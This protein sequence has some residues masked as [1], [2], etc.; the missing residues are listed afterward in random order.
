MTRLAVL[1]CSNCGS[2]SPPNAKFC[3]ECGATL[4]RPDAPAA[5]TVRAAAREPARGER[6]QLTVMF[7]DL[8]GS[9]ALAERLDPE[10]LGDILHAYHRVCSRIVERFGGHIHQYLGDGVMAYFSYPRAQE[11]A[12]QRSLRAALAIVE[13][14]ERLRCDRGQPLAVRVGIHTGLVVVGDHTLAVGETPNIAARLQALADPNTVVIGAATQRLVEQDFE[15]RPLGSYALKGLSRPL[16]VYRVEREHMARNRFDAEAAAALTPLVGRDRELGRLLANWRGA[17][18]GRGRAVLIRGEPGIGKSRLLTALKAEVA[19]CPGAW[20][21]ECYSSPCYQSRLLHPVAKLLSH[22]VLRFEPGD[23]PAVKLRKLEGWLLQ[24]GLD[25]ERN[26]PLLAGLL[27]L[28]LPG[29]PRSQLTLAAQ[30]ALETVLLHILLA[31]AARQPVLVAFEDLHWADTATLALLERLLAAVADARVLVV[32]TARSGFTPP[33][34][35]AAGLDTLDLA[36]LPAGQTERLARLVA[37][38]KRLPR[39]LLARLVERSDGVPLFVEELTRS[40][41]ESGLLREREDRFEA[42]GPVPTLPIPATLHDALAFRLEQAYPAKAVAQLAATLGRKFSYGLLRAVCPLD[43]GTLMEGLR[44]LERMGL[45]CRRGAGTAA[46]YSFRHAL[47]QEKAYGSLL[48]SVRRRYHSRISRC[49]D[50]AA[51]APSGPARA[52]LLRRA[53]PS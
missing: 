53:V 48:R 38:G 6:R 10:E 21:V 29:R 20:L 44:Q 37:K 35:W 34:G 1:H 7:C 11:D 12:A 3:M 17:A 16:P 32:L 15:C 9:T 27:E 43:E 33:R 24:Y 36:H 13:A 18:A 26:L 19:A 22:R 51:P 50:T 39:E 49:L 28:P 47:I 30:A 8:V 25:P 52:A 46:V 40:V 2:D 45:L 23:V 5:G 41:L 31:R 4:R 14:M 42:E